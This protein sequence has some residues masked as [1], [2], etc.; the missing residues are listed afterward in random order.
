M[1]EEYMG[2]IAEMSVT[3]WRNPVIKTRTTL[4]SVAGLWTTR[5]AWQARR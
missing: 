2:T 3:C 1:N 4:R 5:S